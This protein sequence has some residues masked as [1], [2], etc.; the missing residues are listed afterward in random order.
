M[1]AS[2]NVLSNLNHVC[3]FFMLYT[4]YDIHRKPNIKGEIGY[5]HWCIYVFVFGSCKFLCF[6]G[7]K[8]GLENGVLES[9]AV[10]THT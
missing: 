8:S 2:S 1:N 4:S 5:V 3:L 10:S 6:T 7:V 9:V